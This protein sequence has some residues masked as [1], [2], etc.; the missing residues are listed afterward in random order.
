MNIGNILIIISMI[1]LNGGLL[2][3]FFM[4][5][6]MKLAEQDVKIAEIYTRL[7]KNENKCDDIINKMDTKLDIINDKIT[8]I[9]VEIAKK[10]K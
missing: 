4:K 2:I 3:T 6:K 5:I 8:N 9:I 7:N 10:S 1:L